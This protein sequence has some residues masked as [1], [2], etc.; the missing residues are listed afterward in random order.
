MDTDFFGGMTC[1]TR[2]SV[3]RAMVEGVPEG[4]CIEIGYGTIFLAIVI[5]AVEVMVLQWI[6]RRLLAA[7][8]SKI[9][10]SRQM[11]PVWS[12]REGREGGPIR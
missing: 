9:G 5:F 2:V 11:G 1:E 7:A 6:V 10:P 4:G 3:F 8:R 12:A